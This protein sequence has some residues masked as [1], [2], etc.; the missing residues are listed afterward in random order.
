MT[1]LKY[2]WIPVVLLAFYTSCFTNVK[3]K[4]KNSLDYL[5]GKMIKYKCSGETC[6]YGYMSSHTLLKTLLKEYGLV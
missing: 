1:Y 5:W 6:C 3:I 4:L 2:A